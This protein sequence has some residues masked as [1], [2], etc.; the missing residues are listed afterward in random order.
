MEAS[1]ALIF[2]IGP[3]RLFLA[4]V[5]WKRP[6]FVATET[7]AVLTPLQPT[8]WKQAAKGGMLGRVEQRE[9]IQNQ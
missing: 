7:V 1:F 2:P 5:R 8:K 4:L 3:V 6:H 9:S